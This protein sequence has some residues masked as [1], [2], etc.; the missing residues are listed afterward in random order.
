RGG[1][2]LASLVAVT[3]SHGLSE[4]T[5]AYLVGALVDKSIVSASFADGAARYD[6]LDTVR[7][8]V[9]DGLAATGA[10][11]GVRARHAEYFA[12]LADGAS[13]GLRAADWLGW[14]GRLEAEN[15]NVWA[16]LGYAGEA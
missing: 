14:R 1:A 9:V 7:E 11:S 4:S 3:E 6:M 5:V 16:A 15:D 10:V 13:A 8:Y 2:S 12:E